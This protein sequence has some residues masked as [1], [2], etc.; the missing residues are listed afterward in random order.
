[1]PSDGA[2]ALRIGASE[3]GGAVWFA[4]TRSVVRRLGPP[5]VGPVALKANWLLP[6]SKEPLTSHFLTVAPVA[7]GEQA[8]VL[9]G[10]RDIFLLDPRTGK[11][12]RVG[13]FGEKNSPTVEPTVAGDTLLAIAGTTLYATQL[14]TG[15]AR[16]KFESGESGSLPVTIAGDTVLWLTQRFPPD[17]DG[18]TQLPVG[19]LHALDLATGKPRWQRPLT[20]FT[21]VGQAI[22]SGT[23]VITTAPVAA[24]DLAT[25]EPRWTAQVSDSPLGGGVVN[26]AGD[27]LFVGLINNETSVASIA[28][29]RAAD[30]AVIWQAPIGKS[31]LHPLERPALSGEVLVVP[32][33]S[34]EILGLA[35]TDGAELWR[36]KPAKPRYGAI[37]VANGR[38]WFI[39]SNARVVALDAKT[40]RLAA[41]LALD[42]DIGNIQ[43]FTPRPLIMGDRVVVP[44]AM[45]LLGL[46]EPAAAT[47]PETTQP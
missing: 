23:M 25:G 16:W 3:G 40:G 38:V 5:I 34:G 29:I 46:T 47:Q 12:N 8:L 30:G 32:L 27:T 15:A 24:F 11:G 2:A 26:A 22:V 36:H 44:L 31:P 45:A 37:S 28:A 13:S 33:W 42:I 19:T 10:E 21:G 43:A 7:Y 4:D 9:D 18:K 39:E 41:Q 14:P 1:M 17:V 35:V 6:F 20:G